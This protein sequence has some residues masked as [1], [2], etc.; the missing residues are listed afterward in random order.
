MKIIITDA[1]ANP[2][3]WKAIDAPYNA[4][5]VGALQK[6][7]KGRGPTAWLRWDRDNR[8]WLFWDTPEHR[9]EMLALLALYYPNTEIVFQ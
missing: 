5:F 2:V 4:G 7:D 6:I 9:A 1:N 8:L 3:F